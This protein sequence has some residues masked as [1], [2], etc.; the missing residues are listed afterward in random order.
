MGDAGAD[1]DTSDEVTDSAIDNTVDPMDDPVDAA[2]DHSDSTPSDTV[3]VT[4]DD[5]TEPHIGKYWYCP[6]A[7]GGDVIVLTAAPAHPQPPPDTPITVGLPLHP[8][9]G[10]VDPGVI[11]IR[12]HE[13]RILPLQ[14]RVVSRW[15][16][17]PDGTEAIRWVLLTFPASFEWD[18]TQTYTVRFDG[19]SNHAP[20]LTVTEEEDRFVV[21][22][23]TIEV[24]IGKDSRILSAR[25]RGENL[26]DTT[27][28]SGLVVTDASGAEHGVS[29]SSI[30]E[31]VLE[32]EGP[33]RVVIRIR[34]TMD[35]DF[36]NPYGETWGD[37]RPESEASGYDPSSDE[38]EALDFT[39]RYVLH[40]FSPTIGVIVTLM[41]LNRCIAG[42]SHPVCA[43][44]HTPNS[45]V[46][47]DASVVLS[48]RY[49]SD[50][51][52]VLEG[53]L[54]LSERIAG[55]FRPEALD[56]EL[57]DTMTFY[58][59]SSG[60]DYWNRYHEPYSDVHFDR[61]GAF[62]T[63]RG[64]VL[65]RDGVEIES[66]DQALPSIQ[67]STTG[68]EI[69]AALRD[70]WQNYPTALRW[71]G[72]RLETSLLAGEFP[73]MHVFRAG[74]A[75]SWELSIALGAEAA[76]RALSVSSDL[77]PF[78]DP[79][80]MAASC[81]FGPIFP[82]Q[83]TDDP[84][85]GDYELYNQAGVDPA[86]S[87]SHGLS[88]YDYASLPVNIDRADFY[89]WM[90]WGAHP[91]DFEGLSGA[92]GCKYEMNAG[93][94]YQ[95]A[96]TADRRFWELARASNRHAADLYI[97]HTR[98]PA[99][100]EGAEARWWHGGWFGHVFHEN[101]EQLDPLRGSSSGYPD[102]GLTFGAEGLVM[103]WFLT[104]YPPALDSA[105][106]LA[107]HVS[108]RMHH[109]GSEYAYTEDG[110]TVPR[111]TAE[112]YRGYAYHGGHDAY[113][114]EEEGRT[115]T[116]TI[117]TLVWAMRAH[118]DER[119]MQALRDAVVDVR[120]TDE[121]LAASVDPVDGLYLHAPVTDPGHALFGR[122]SIL[123]WKS[124][125]FGALALYVELLYEMGIVDHRLDEAEG[126]LVERAEWFTHSGAM[127]RWPVGTSVTVDDGYGS[128]T[129]DGPGATTPY[130]YDWST[131]ST[132][133][134]DGYFTA[135]QLLGL[136][137]GLAAAY[138]LTG[139]V[140][141]LEAARDIFRTG[142]SYSNGAA[143]MGGYSS[144]KEFTFHA[145]QGLRFGAIHLDTEI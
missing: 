71:T 55:G 96:R 34:G 107:D 67:I 20:S 122:S 106:E 116:N 101:R 66:G 11:S 120:R 44:R 3:D 57:G 83:P 74:E 42:T 91:L 86:A 70:P 103:Y 108:W 30:H 40:S 87:R 43:Q 14:T 53:D 115:S 61:P 27:V 32:T 29:G 140:G 104:G 141:Y 50:G 72:D 54:P 33:H 52:A 99:W 36:Q 28:D 112:G 6:P 5:A 46:V 139:D 65:W 37:G 118:P 13:D 79:E 51:Y 76:Q 125:V 75:K 127:A 10:I 26:L 123:W 73:R 100:E 130:V 80:Y 136:P 9:R 38:T 102:V 138:L 98:R 109:A 78:P 90:H 97:L 56:L 8:E 24:H 105:V 119:Y 128:V 23:D 135:L 88:W 85:F 89:G 12:D 68:G 7:P 64:W 137:D 59:A 4:E 81:G 2:F 144:V 111:V 49:V 142:S 110:V 114:G 94:I 82:A 58:Q 19:A 145:R 62:T 48:P 63:R 45:L 129:I 121:L 31:A 124:N 133:P 41:N 16:D 25:L 117:N 17:A 22:N 15:G 143:W 134:D 95:F 18:G 113:D 92:H 69:A 93:L 60:T 77:L 131:T 132:D 39:I 35:H 126:L 21:Q 84:L 1:P 47:E